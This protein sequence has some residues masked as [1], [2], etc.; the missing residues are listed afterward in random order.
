LHRTK[1]LWKSLEKL[2]SVTHDILTSWQG[3]GIDVVIAPGF[4]FPAPPVKHPAR[5]VPCVSY[6]A[7]YNVLDFPAGCVPITRVIPQDEVT[8]I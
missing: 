3:Q 2:D 7:A 1:N 8:K 4:V 6:T 5:L